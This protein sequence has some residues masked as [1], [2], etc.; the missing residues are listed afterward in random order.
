[1]ASFSMTGA[2]GSTNHYSRTSGLPLTQLHAPE[3]PCTRRVP[4]DHKLP[5]VM[6]E[7]EG[8]LWSGLYKSL[9]GS[10]P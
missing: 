5:S 3:C 8:S 1:M 4:P 7:T 2:P 9:R 6:D 10:L